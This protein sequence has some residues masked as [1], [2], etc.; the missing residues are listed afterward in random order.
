[1]IPPVDLLED[2]LDETPFHAGQ[3]EGE[4]DP[5]LL[6]DAIR[7]FRSNTMAA[8][9]LTF[10]ILLILAALFAPWISPHDPYRVALDERLLPPSATYWLGT[11]KFGRDLLTRILYGA[12]I[13]LIVGTVPSCISLA[14]GT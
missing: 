8:I 4:S 6:R 7:D 12:R 3:A 1:M 9:G 13:S 2:R 10:V 11:D 14:I 5:S